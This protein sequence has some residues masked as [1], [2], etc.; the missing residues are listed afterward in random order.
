ML[1]KDSE[2]MVRTHRYLVDSQVLICFDIIL[3]FSSA[4]GKGN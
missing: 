3:L 2:Q 4:A 1:L